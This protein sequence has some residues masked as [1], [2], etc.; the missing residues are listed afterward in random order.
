[1]Q[2]HCAGMHGTSIRRAR[3]AVAIVSLVAVVVCCRGRE[4]GGEPRSDPSG[5]SRVLVREARDVIVVTIDTLRYDA[6]GYSGS[7][8]AETPTLDRMAAEGVA[9]ERAHAHAVVTLPSHAS[10]LTGLY[11]FQHGIRDN[12]R[13]TARSDVR[14]LATILKAAG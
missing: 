5:P 3:F 1:M 11:P 7:G 8:K 10:I 12:A 13:F 4:N 14:G 2:L 9:F 6:V